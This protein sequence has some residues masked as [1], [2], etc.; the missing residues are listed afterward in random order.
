MNALRELRRDVD[1]KQDEFASLLNVSL[2]SLRTW[3]S[4]RR[5]VPPHIIWIS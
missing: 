5:P 2:E 1:L 4:G 3:D